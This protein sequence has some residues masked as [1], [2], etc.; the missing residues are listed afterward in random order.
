MKLEMIDDLSEK[1]AKRL[2]K[3]L[4]KALDKLDFDDIFGGEGWR[5]YLGFE[6]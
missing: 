3:K 1:G 4:V 5:H 2:L 6:D